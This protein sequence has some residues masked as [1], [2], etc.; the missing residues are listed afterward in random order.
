LCKIR[1]ILTAVEK[2]RFLAD[3][4][5]EAGSKMSLLLEER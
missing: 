4:M 2:G 3:L 5:D 1:Y